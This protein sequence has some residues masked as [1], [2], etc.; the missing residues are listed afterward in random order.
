MD[1]NKLKADITELLKKHAKPRED[2]PEA[3]REYFTVDKVDEMIDGLTKLIVDYA[4]HSIDE[5]E[6][7]SSV[8]AIE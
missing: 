1:E 2:V 3:V 5:T 7:W 8:I 6:S 4:K